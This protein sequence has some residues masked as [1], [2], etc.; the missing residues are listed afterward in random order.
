M[1]FR[2]PVSDFRCIL[3]NVVGFPEVSATERLESATLDLVD[4]ILGEGAKLCD[5]TLA[6]LNAIGNSHPARLEYGI[7][8]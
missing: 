4:A 3:Q 7:V 1:S 6:P 8:R 2:T 5:G